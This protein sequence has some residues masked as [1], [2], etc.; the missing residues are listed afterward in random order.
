MKI[1]WNEAW[2]T[3]FYARLRDGERMPKEH[4]GSIFW[5]TAHIQICSGCTLRW[6]NLRVKT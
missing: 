3:N 5:R 1:G 2:L 6:V 4:L